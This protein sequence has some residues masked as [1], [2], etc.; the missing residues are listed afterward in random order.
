[1]AMRE[2]GWPRLL[3]IAVLLAAVCALLVARDGCGPARPAELV[4]AGARGRGGAGSAL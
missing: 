4:P 2:I 3:L 1:M